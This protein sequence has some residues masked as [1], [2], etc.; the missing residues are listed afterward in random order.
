MKQK[1]SY[2]HKIQ[3]AETKKEKKI[4][5]LQKLWEDKNEIQDENLILVSQK[6][7]LTQMVVEVGGW[8]GSFAGGL[9]HSYHVT[10]FVGKYT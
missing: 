9:T 6:Y 5:L 1:G 8:I 3:H 4:E 2:T 10:Q 7:F